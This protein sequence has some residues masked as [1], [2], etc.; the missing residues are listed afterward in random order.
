MTKTTIR[1]AVA[2][3][4]GVAVNEHFGHARAFHVYDLTADACR[5]LGQ[6]EVRHYCLGGS[7]D[8]TALAD[9]LETIKDCA[10]VFVAK[11]GDGPTEKLAARN[12]SAVA[13]YAWEEIEPSLLDYAARRLAG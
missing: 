9:I 10:A 5:L 11:I 3:K 7:S 12:I 6:R 2:T 8:K 1:V 4:E 13:D